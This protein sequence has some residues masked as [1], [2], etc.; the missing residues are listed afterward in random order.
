MK[1][2]FTLIAFALCAVCANAAEEDFAISA[3]W[4]WGWGDR[5]AEMVDGILVVN[6]SGNGA[7]HSTG[8]DPA[9]DFSAYSSMTVVVESYNGGWGSIILKKSDNEGENITVGIPNTETQKAVVIELDPKVN[10]WLAGEVTQFALQGDANSTLKISRIYLTEAVETQ[11]TAIWEGECSFG[12]WAEG[13]K[14]EAE[15]FANANA[16]DVIE[17]IYTTDD[18]NPDTWW[19]FKT[20]YDGTETTL[21]GN[22]SELNEWGCATVAK[23]SSSY[24]I[25]L[26][27]TDVTELKEKGLYV[28][29]YYNIVTKV[30]L[31]QP[32]SSGIN[33]AIGA[34]KAQNNIRYNFAGQRVGNG[35]KFYIMNGKKYMK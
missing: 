21:E 1:K 7:A 14:I 6:Y 12:G 5:T 35:A 25:A 19:Q 32:I 33:E 13:F 29:G 2:L 28:N 8:W 16:G 23:G 15:K 11:S 3:D 24:K 9:K 30:N 17:F 18:T 10:P 26:T 31:I 27:E 34:P 20:I 22:K 4:G